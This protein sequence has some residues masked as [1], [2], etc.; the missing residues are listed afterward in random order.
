MAA[1]A[2]L[3]ALLPDIDAGAAKIA[4][5][6]ISRISP[7]APVSMTAREAFGHRGFAHSLAGAA[8]AGAAAIT[9][10]RFPGIPGAAA[11]LTGYASRLAGDA[12]TVSGIPVVFPDRTR[13]Y[14]LPKALRFVTGSRTG[15][16]LLVLFAE[17]SVALLL[18]LL[19]PR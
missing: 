2:A 9:A 10:G 19:L 1:C 7:L 12:C 14:V 16:F 6:S 11:L 15:D 13:R 3:G 5:L 4:T 8:L 17:A 18:P